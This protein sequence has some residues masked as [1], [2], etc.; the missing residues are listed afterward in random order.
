MVSLL[1][2]LAICL[3]LLIPR[4][5]APCCCAEKVPDVPQPC[6]PGECSCNNGK[7]LD[8]P[9]MITYFCKA[10]VTSVEFLLFD[11]IPLS[12]LSSRMT[13]IIFPAPWVICVLV[14][15]AAGTRKYF[16]MRDSSA[17]RAEGE[18]TV[19]G[20]PVA[21]EALG[22][23]SDAQKIDEKI[24]H[25]QTVAVE[26]PAAKVNMPAK[27]RMAI[28]EGF[29]MVELQNSSGEE[30]VLEMLTLLY[31]NPAIHNGPARCQHLRKKLRADGSADKMIAY[32]P[33]A[34][35]LN[36]QEVWA[37]DV[38]QG[39]RKSVMKQNKQRAPRLSFFRNDG[40]NV[41]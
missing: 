37:S 32:V 8:Y 12:H 5:C 36:L 39:A 4:C 33:E 18:A 30:S 2:S 23:A 3:A 11:F 20:R 10:C 7:L 21:L 1:L 14:S 27:D 31:Q 6:P 26:E 34:D 16:L 35:L 17:D 15:L 19:V 24:D 9:L 28:P 29:G 41:S 25:G 13:R 22:D 40:S 38:M